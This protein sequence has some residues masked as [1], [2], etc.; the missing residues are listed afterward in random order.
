M[1][2]HVYGIAFGRAE[3]L[4]N[5]FPPAFDVA[6]SLPM[7]FCAV[8]FVVF[9]KETAPRTSVERGLYFFI[10][11]YLWISVPLHIRTLVTWDTHYI[12]RFPEWYT[13]IILP[14]MLMMLVVCLRVRFKAETA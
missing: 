10:A 13:F 14:L 6:L 11:F 4:R 8:C 3:L 2:L 1:C 5:V 9:R 7:T 12:E